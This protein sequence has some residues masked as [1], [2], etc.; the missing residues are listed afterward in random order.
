MANIF[1]QA[2]EIILTKTCGE[3]TEDEAKLVASASSFV[4]T[5]LS[6]VEPECD[7]E[8]ISNGLLKLAV[9]VEEVE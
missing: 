3:M 5:Q 2:Y 8:L 4:A 6:R 1:R 9:M 7:D